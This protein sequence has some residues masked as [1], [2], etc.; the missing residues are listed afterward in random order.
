M[1]KEFIEFL[2]NYKVVGLACAVI[3]GGKLNDFISSLVNDL[4]MPL[5]LSPALKAAHVED[6]KK[7]NIDGI[8][9]GKVLGASIDFVV[10]ALIVFF[11]SKLILKEETV[12]KK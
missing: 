11:F 2:K 6:I 10:V 4:V 8:Y 12:A 5:I 9:Y 3:I 7:L 1:Y